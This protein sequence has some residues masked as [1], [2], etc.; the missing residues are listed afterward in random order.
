M[1]VKIV[2]CFIIH[3]WIPSM[4]RFF[5]P[6]VFTALMYLLSGYIG[7]KIAIPPGFSTVL[8]PAAGVALGAVLGWTW[9]ALPGVFFGSLLVNLYIAFSTTGELVYS[10]VS[11]IAIGATLQALIGCLLITFFLNTPF[12]FDKP[13]NVFWFIFLGGVMSTLIAPT[14][15]CIS[16]LYFG[17]IGV[18]LFFSNWLNW[19]IGDSIGVIVVT[20]WLLIAFPHLAKSKLP[21][22]KPFVIILLSITVVTAVISIAAFHFDH[23]KQKAEFEKNADM[24][25]FYLKSRLK[26]SID[27]LYGLAGFVQSVERITKDNF[28]N[29]TQHILERDPAILGVT[30]NKQIFS[31]E[32]DTWR[33]FLRATYDDSLVNIYERGERFERLALQERDQYVVLSFVEPFEEFA[34]GVGFDTYS[35][36][37]R[38]EAMDRAYLSASVVPSDY[39]PLQQKDGSK[40]ITE[41]FFLPVFK[42]F[43]NASG[44]KVLDGFVT[45][46]IS[47]TELS[48]VLQVEHGVLPNTA[49]YLLHKSLNQDEPSIIAQSDS[50]Y[51][52]KDEVLIRLKTNDFP[53]IARHTMPIGDSSW[54]LVQVSYEYNMYHPW[55]THFVLAGGFLLTG[56][57]GWFLVLI[58]SKT[59]QM[60]TE[61]LKRTE[62]LSL[63]NQSLIESEVENTQAKREAELA[64]KAKSE[65]LANMS[66]EIRTPLNGIMGA[67]SLLSHDKLEGSQRNIVQLSY[68]SAETLLD[69]IND[70]LDLSKIEMGD[71]DFEEEEFD[72]VEL[73]ED[74][75]QALVVKAHEKGIDL[76]C[77]MTVLTISK[78]IGDSARIRQVL[79]NLVGNAIKFT[80]KGCVSVSVVVRRKE[81]GLLQV[82]IAVKDTGIGISYTD[83]QKLF[84]RFK[85]AD[86]S[87]TRKYG[88]TGL[89]L[90]ISKQLVDMMGGRI[91][92]TSEIGQ[93]SIFWFKLSLKESTSILEGDHSY[94]CASISQIL[95]ITD[96]A[97]TGQYVSELL[98]RWNIE[99][100]VVD[101]FSVAIERYQNQTLPFQMSIEDQNLMTLTSSKEFDIWFFLCKRQDI[102]RVLLMNSVPVNANCMTTFDTY[103]TQLTKPVR[104]SELFNVLMEDSENKE[105]GLLHKNNGDLEKKQFHNHTLLVEDNITNQIVA[106]GLLEMKG[107]TVTIANNGEEALQVVKDRRFDIIFMDC[108]MP[109][110]DGYEATK[111]IRLLDESF[112]ETSPRVPII[113]L[114]ANA[115]KGDDKLCFEAGMDDFMP[116]PIDP[117]VLVEKLSHWLNN[118]V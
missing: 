116:K 90:A 79:M 31:D 46:G 41:I 99:C 100:V 25:A 51:L 93:G 95:L 44:R 80:L 89:G 17:V 70:I 64:N 59:A 58:A 72:L 60:E 102:K 91:G 94:E 103:S 73:I 87:T 52:A 9:R 74:V 81:E 57:F 12:G 26:K 110:M 115:M 24:V 66:H 63:L 107:L 1:N 53:M 86:N 45:A 48:N 35:D 16:L 54:E 14:V 3:D 104:K 88:G 105:D 37:S 96:N 49:L 13:Q 38:K 65:F 2:C 75:G 97:E 6:T 84:T 19:W 15:G 34:K 62:A 83:Q 55:S 113:A 92:V 101:K 8:W 20:P 22:I 68:K 36:A 77:P 117:L 21:K 98:L 56:L 5:F 118:K 78:V 71:I 40:I 47:V 76:I 10:L 39:I 7:Q 67:L 4:Y 33:E 108:Q 85:Q 32:L 109:V 11:F 50:G 106:R 112:A 111:H 28:Q 69:I 18:D 29:Y 61:V 23:T 42:P 27:S 82:E 30:W 43:L 114:S